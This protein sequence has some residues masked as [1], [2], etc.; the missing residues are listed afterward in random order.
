MPVK[1]NTRVSDI[2]KYILGKFPI[3]EADEK[4]T[5]TIEI[6][7]LDGMT[8]LNTVEDNSIDLV[9][10]DPPYIIS[11]DSGMN[12]HYNDVK[13]NEKNIKFAKTPED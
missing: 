11:R 8:Y 3:Y 13:I 12:K 2:R 1:G 7:N 6:A 5:T 10:T 4:K 9:L